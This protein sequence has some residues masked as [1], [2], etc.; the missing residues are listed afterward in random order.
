MIIVIPKEQNPKRE[1]RKK[2]RSFFF[3]SQFSACTFNILPFVAFVML[4]DGHLN[5]LT[6]TTFFFFFLECL[7]R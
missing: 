5:I 6:L 2:R 4:I 1:R 7:D 3:T